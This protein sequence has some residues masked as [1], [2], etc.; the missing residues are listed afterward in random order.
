MQKDK[1]KS[2]SIKIRSKTGILTVAK[3]IQLFFTDSSG[4][5]K[6]NMW[7]DFRREKKQILV[8]DQRWHASFLKWWKSI[9]WTDGWI[10][11]G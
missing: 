3:I 5:T 9:I 4:F 10:M 7:Y 1:M 8:M 6:T 2:I 11:T